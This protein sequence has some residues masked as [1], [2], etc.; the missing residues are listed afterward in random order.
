MG[1]RPG[2][3]VDFNP[4][5]DAL[6]AAAAFANLCNPLLLLVA[7]YAPNN[8]VPPSAAAV[9]VLSINFLIPLVCLIVGVWLWCKKR[10]ELVIV[11]TKLE[12][13]LTNEQYER[14][15]R[16]IKQKDRDLE[17]GTS[18]TIA[19]SFMGM[20]FASFTAFVLVF[21]S[22]IFVAVQVSVRT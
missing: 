4:L 20:A 10:N 22:Y 3:R 18:R 14:A 7:F 8:A 5:S 1:R 19:S 11:V 13:G 2:S 6:S 16:E 15:S 21:V 17:L 9:L 12:G